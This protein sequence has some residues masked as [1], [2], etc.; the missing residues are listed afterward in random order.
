MHY[1]ADVL[2]IMC[3][4]LHPFSFSDLVRARSTAYV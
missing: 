2:F 1:L 3:R 4:E